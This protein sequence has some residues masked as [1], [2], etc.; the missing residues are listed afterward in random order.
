MKIT[1]TDKKLQIFLVC[2]IVIKH[3]ISNSSNYSMF[4]VKNADI[5]KQNLIFFSRK[6]MRCKFDC[7]FHCETFC[8]LSTLKNPN[9]EHNCL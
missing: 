3:K 9:L 5:I 7:V 8:V 6:R 4:L 2:K 1:E